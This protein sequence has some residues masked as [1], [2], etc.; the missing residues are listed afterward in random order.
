MMTIGFAASCFLA[1]AF[2]FLFSWSVAVLR[3][4]CGL[5]AC[6]LGATLG[7]VTIAGFRLPHITNWYL[8]SLLIVAGLILMFVPL[9]ES[10][11]L[12]G[13]PFAEGQL[14]PQI[15]PPREQRT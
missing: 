9:R 1:F 15:L 13:N 3:R 7:V 2:L 8:P 14:P 11:D 12:V 10:D 5:V 6:G 4:Q